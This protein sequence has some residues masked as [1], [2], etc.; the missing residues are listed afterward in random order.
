V[1]VSPQDAIMTDV[2]A[3]QTTF[4]AIQDVEVEEQMIAEDVK[5][6][7]ETVEAQQQEIQEATVEDV[8]VVERTEVEKP[9]EV[10]QMLSS[11]EIGSETAEARDGGNYASISQNGRGANIRSEPSLA[12]EVV[13]TVP[14]GFPLAIIERQDDWVLVEDFRERSG[15]VYSTLLSDYGTVVIKVGKGNLRSEPRLTADIIA[16]LDYGM[17]M[18]LNEINGEWMQVSNPDGLVGWL[19]NEVIWP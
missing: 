16:K 8:K 12:A 3:P 19:H 5:V 15:W 9:V 2:V 4:Q 6:V 17:V 13:R 1:I 11:I 18:F 7:T 14:P 10:K